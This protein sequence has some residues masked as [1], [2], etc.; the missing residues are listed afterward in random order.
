MQVIPKSEHGSLDW[1]RERHRDA[2]GQVLFGASDCP[3]L[4]GA[5]P[6]TKR[7]DL[8]INKLTEP[9]VQEFNP[10]FHKGNIL[11]PV[12][13]QEASAFL[14][15]PIHTPNVIYREGRFSVSLDGVDNPYQPTVIVEAKTTSRYR[16]EFP[17]DLPEEWLWQ[18][19]CQQGVVSP[20]LNEPF[21]GLDEPIPVYFVVLD[22]DQ[23]ISCV[24]MPN[25]P[26]AYQTLQVQAEKLGKL[27]ES[28]KPAP[29]DLDQFS[30]EQI[31][32]IYTAEPT[33]IELTDDAMELVLE[34]EVA[35]SK[36]KEADDREKQARD[37]LAQLL[38]QHENGLYQGQ[39]IISWKQQKGRKSVDV[40]LMRNENPELVAQYEK[41]GAPFRVMR[42][43]KIG[44]T[45]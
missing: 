24:K 19:W 20:H 2:D 36:K 41:E 18:G 6:Y 17:E 43:H 4:M 10:V 35:R 32:K 21:R 15:R 45:S 44:E 3:A 27:I 1:L 14:Q 8:F 9:V 31:A 12:L 26:K 11:E 39:K 28:G 13:L 33:S 30:A 7:T 37:A 22:R 40:T 25:N 23:R 16:I 38:L 29:E 42:T 34:L 5:S